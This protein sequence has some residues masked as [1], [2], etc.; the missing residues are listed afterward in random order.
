MS[1]LAPSISTRTRV[2][3]LWIIPIVALVAGIWM[4]VQSYLSEGPTIT[5]NFATAE[6]LAA[7]KTKVK[8]LSVEV[9]LVE[10]VALNK[11]MSGVKVTVSLDKE[12]TPL[13]REDTEF[14]VVRARVGAGGISGINTLLS[15]GYIQLAPGTGSPGK[16][17]FK[18]LENPPRTP[19]GAPGTRLTL[20]SI[21]ASISAG[22]PIIY[23][24]FK[25]G[26]V[27]SMTFDPE[28]KRANYEIFIDAPYDQLVHD[29]TRFWNISGFGI[30]ASAAGVNLRVG[31]MDTILLGGVAF[32]TPPGLDEGEPVEN[33]TEFRLYKSYEDILKSPYEFGTYFVIE[34]GQSLAGLVAGAP[35]TY[36]GIQL[37]R[38]ER[39]LI[40]E[41]T[42]GGIEGTA[43]DIPVLIY[44]E[45]GRVA[46][47]DSQASVDALRKTIEAGVA[48]GLRA[49]LQTGNL[50][51][52]RK[53]INFDYFS[54]SEEAQIGQFDNWTTIP[55]KE[56]GVGEITEQI[57]TLLAK[58]N[59]LPLDQ[60]ISG[61]NRT[62]DNAAVMV[63]NLN[64]TMISLNEILSADGTQAL[65]AELASTLE[66]LRSV[67]DGFSQDAQLY[68]DANSSLSSLDRTLE[69][70]N[71]L[72]R[73]LSERP[74]SV[75]FSSPTKED[76]VPE[77]PQ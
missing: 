23:E 67:L 2:S 60:T 25:V 73:Q 64:E 72:T 40:K 55:T 14:W 20:S 37:G 47:P 41:L 62:L 26:R 31:T 59:S 76:P 34:F 51:T 53:L 10:A 30:D 7:G 74:N 71:R 3:P 36:R 42:A 57:N 63:S 56:T 16:R 38:V 66:E 69:N 21:E 32:G 54:N 29:S 33:G 4:V 22:D 35:V 9:G 15:G 8:M 49:T 11:D 46:L 18:G 52:G 77:A 19:V 5:I 39:I 50:L 65:P 13:L 43:N 24:G 27:E 61:A 58:L 28:V 6:G 68:Q 17:E 70:L 1:E 12:V 75:L 44:L 45:P 48:R